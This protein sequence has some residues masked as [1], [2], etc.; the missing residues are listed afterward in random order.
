MKRMKDIRIMKGKKK[1]EKTVFLAFVAHS[2]T[3]LMFRFGKHEKSQNITQLK[4][5]D[6]QTRQ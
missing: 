1:K 4:L 5:N 2:H 6:K 3:I